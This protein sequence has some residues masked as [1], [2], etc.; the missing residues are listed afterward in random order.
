MLNYSKTRFTKKI[1]LIFINV[2]IAI[3]VNAATI[4]DFYAT[5]SISDDSD[6]IKMTTNLF[7]TQMQSLSGYIIVDKRDTEYSETVA[8]SSH[9]SFYAEIHEDEENN[10]IC[11]LTA[12]KQ[13]SNIAVSE[14][15]SY[16][17]YFK[18]LTD[19]KNSLENLLNNIETGKQVSIQNR[20]ET[21]QGSSQSLDSIAGTWG[22][23]DFVEKVILMR[24][25]RGF[26][27]F[28][29]GAS[30][31]VL[32]SITDK[33]IEITQTGKS[34]PSFYP[35]LPRDIAQKLASTADP[36]KWKLTLSNNTTLSGTRTVFEI[37][38]DSDN[39]IK[40]ITS[41]VTWTKR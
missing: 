29:N 19:A 2:A 35:N 5:Q 6:M 34:N 10:W 40:S 16:A 25:G 17:S 28:N 12:I 26:I 21:S 7:Y 9:I 13:N 39:G 11:T 31:N 8:I 41:A 22:G 20:P 23:E 18:I 27:I 3:T 24:S 14:T 33:N 36:L 37:D 4:I 1:I 38:T 32:I 30:M 15:K